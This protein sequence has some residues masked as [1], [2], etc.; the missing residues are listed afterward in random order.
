MAYEKAISYLERIK[1]EDGNYVIKFPITTAKEVILNIETGETVEE[2]FNNVVRQVEAESYTLLEDFATLVGK[3]AGLVD[4]NINANHIFR[5]NM[6][7]DDLIT[8]IYGRFQP[9]SVSNGSVDKLSYTMKNPIIVKDKPIKMQLKDI[10]NVNGTFNYSVKMTF[11]A[12]DTNPT[13]LDCTDA[14][15]NGDFVSLTKSYEK[16]DGKDW[17]LNFIFEADR[18]SDTGTIE[19]VDYM[20]LHI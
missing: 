9:G 10:K 8:V 12:L 16:E 17:A 6:K 19:V 11:N 18:T 20:L 5:D 4:D 7:T 14:Y 15:K 2:I 13:W 1:L 3:V